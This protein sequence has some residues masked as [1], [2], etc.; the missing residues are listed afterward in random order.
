VD[1]IMRWLDR[2][3]WKALPHGAI[4]PTDRATM[5]AARDRAADAAI[6]S[7]RIGALRELRRS[8]LDW[9][10]AQYRRDGLN[11]IYFS[12]AN[13]PPE[14]RRDAIEMLIDAATAYLLADVLPEETTTTLLAPFDVWSGGPNFPIEPE[15]T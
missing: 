7:G 11:A 4:P 5:E 15:E 8:I 14:Q 2:G 1:S 3:G 6:V 10:L 9:S 12:G 13:E